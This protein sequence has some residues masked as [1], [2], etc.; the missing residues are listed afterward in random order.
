[1]KV[2]RTPAD[3]CPTCASSGP[4]QA[5]LNFYTDDGTPTSITVCRQCSPNGVVF[6]IQNTL[7][8]KHGRHLAHYNTEMTWPI[9]WLAITGDPESPVVQQQRY[10]RS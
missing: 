8:D 3:P 6:N 7:V 5:T 1:M 10:E 2:Y 9:D 4:P